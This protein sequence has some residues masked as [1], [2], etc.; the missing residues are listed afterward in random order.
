MFLLPFGF[1]VR[2]HLGRKGRLKTRPRAVA[3]GSEQF[4][5]TP[6]TSTSRQSLPDWSG[7]HCPDDRLIRGFSYLLDAAKGFEFVEVAAHRR[8]RSAI[9]SADFRHC[10]ASSR[11][12]VID[13]LAPGI[14]LDDLDPL[15]LVLWLLL[16]ANHGL[17]VLA[18]PDALSFVSGDVVVL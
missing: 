18:V 1:K 15:P 13:R 11:N 16:A 8:F 7:L 5:T 14:H 9:V 4:A 2:G 3:F 12:A 10:R 17:E 6:A